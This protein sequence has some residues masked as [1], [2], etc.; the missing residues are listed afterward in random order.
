M[1]PRSTFDIGVFRYV[2]VI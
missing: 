1:L 2:N